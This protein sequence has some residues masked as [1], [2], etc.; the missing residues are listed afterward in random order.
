MTVYFMNLIFLCLQGDTSQEWWFED[1]FVN[2]ININTPEIMIRQGF[3]E[4]GC[5][6]FVPIK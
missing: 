2:I 5:M 4:L 6:F 3:S 1:V